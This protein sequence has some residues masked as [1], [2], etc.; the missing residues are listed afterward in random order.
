VRK[1]RI[2]QR[3]VGITIFI[4]ILLIAFS[5]SATKNPIILKAEKSL[6]KGY[7]AY[8][9]ENFSKAIEYL[10]SSYQLI[11][12]SKTAYYLSRCYFELNDYQKAGSY[13][14]HTLKDKPELS[15]VYRENAKEI[16][17]WAK[18]IKDRP[19]RKDNYIGSGGREINMTGKGDFVEKTLPPNPMETN[20]EL[21]NYICYKIRN[22][23]KDDQYLHIEHGKIESSKINLGWWSAQWI[24]D[25]PLQ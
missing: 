8:K 11:P 19:S 21:S 12:Y 25:P 18:E 7:Q 23:W 1:N 24:I 15:G 14:V 17:A 3:S 5:A 4:S 9:S 20:F 22:R 10:R 16:I 6:N 13:A 2:V